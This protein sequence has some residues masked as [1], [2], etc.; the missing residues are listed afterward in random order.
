MLTQILRR[1][2][3]SF[4]TLNT[5]E[6]ILV[7]AAIGSYVCF[8][9]FFA[10]FSNTFDFGV[11][12]DACRRVMTGDGGQLY[13]ELFSGAARK[14]IVA[15]YYPPPAALV[16]IPFCI[17]PRACS[18]AVF[19]IILEAGLWGFWIL[20]L[21]TYGSRWTPEQR[22][23]SF[24]LVFLFFPLYY[25]I[26]LGQT[27][28]LVI[29]L[30]LIYLR[31]PETPRPVAA[32]LALAAAIMFKTFL[33]ILL[34][35]LALL[36]RWRDLAWTTMWLAALQAASLAVIPLSTQL[37]YWRF[38]RQR[39]GMEA[40]Y[41]NQSLQGVFER[42]LTEN[43]FTLGFHWPL[44]AH[45][46][47]VV[48]AAGILIVYALLMWRVGRQRPWITTFSASIVTA[49]LISPVTETQHLALLLIAFL[50]VLMD[51]PSWKWVLLFGFFA[52]FQ[53]Y[54]AFRYDS[55]ERMWFFARGFWNLVYSLPAF[56]LAAL[57]LRLARDMMAPSAEAV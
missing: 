13:A 42:L 25:G 18:L 31:A 50:P 14:G 39:M 57:W 37:A 1:L 47:Y 45:L 3:E 5:S 27:E 8:G 10:A 23:R 4:E 52:L 12:Y 49:L 26:W 33:G 35:H 29:V 21:R 11:I 54:V 30:L 19:Q 55:T 36:R 48:S 2:R 24:A 16:L 34:F 7:A 38:L 56:A 41:D 28:I 46:F 32:T 44:G 40:F 17:F 6:Q 51:K 22:W 43:R 53:P 9:L 20:W 15:Y